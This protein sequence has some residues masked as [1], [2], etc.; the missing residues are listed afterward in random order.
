RTST[1]RTHVRTGPVW[2]SS[3]PAKRVELAIPAFPSTRADSR[4]PGLG[5]D[6]PS[7]RLS[8]LQPWAD[9]ESSDTSLLAK[10]IERRLVQLLKFQ[11]DGVPIHSYRPILPR[12]RPA[13]SWQVSSKDYA[14]P[15]FHNCRSIHRTGLSHGRS[16]RRGSRAPTGSVPPYRREPATSS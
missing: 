1:G 4:G 14:R 11:L 16:R 7:L 3:L 5:R 9:L 13:E 15:G 6:I 2:K 10:R 8:R 12:R